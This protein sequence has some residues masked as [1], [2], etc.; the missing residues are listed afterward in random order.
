M[1]SVSQLTKAAG[2]VAVGDGDFM[3]EMLRND[4]DGWRGAD[5]GDDGN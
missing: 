5:A 3:T 4:D 2:I 1:S